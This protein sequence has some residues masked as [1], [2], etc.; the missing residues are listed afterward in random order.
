M[1]CDLNFSG[2]YLVVT[3]VWAKLGFSGKLSAEEKRR[4]KEILQ[5]ILP[6]DAGVIV[7]TNSRNASEEDLQSELE[8]LLECL[9]QGKGK[10]CNQ[11]LF[12]SHS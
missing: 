7:R 2:R 5:P 6:D 3:A 1:T 4:L 9:R 11:N 12:F 8:R 10:G